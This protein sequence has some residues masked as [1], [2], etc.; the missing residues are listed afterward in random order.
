MKPVAFIFRLWALLLL[1]F[2]LFSLAGCRVSKQVEKATVTTDLKSVETEV[3]AGVYKAVS[4]SR[5]EKEYGDTLTG[6]MVLP[7]DLVAETW[8]FYNGGISTS[9][10]AVKDSTGAVKMAV[11]SIARPKKEV[12]VRETYTAGDTTT[13]R[14]KQVEEKKI[15]QVKKKDVE[16]KTSPWLP[17]LIWVVIGFAVAIF[18]RKFKKQLL[19]WNR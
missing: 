16:R 3:K 11:E 10:K 4:T 19:I 8:V 7:S 14:T 13:T 15:V 17:L 5:I 2:L 1:L 18:W 6:W 9:V 12:E